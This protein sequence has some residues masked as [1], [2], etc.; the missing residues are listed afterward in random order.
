MASLLEVQVM[1]LENNGSES[2]ALM[3]N[4]FWRAVLNTFIC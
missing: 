3:G 4:E 1:E 2:V